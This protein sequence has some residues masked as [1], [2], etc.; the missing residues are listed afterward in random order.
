MMPLHYVRCHLLFWLWSLSSAQLWLLLLYLCFGLFWFV[1]LFVVVVMVLVA[2]VAIVRLQGLLC[3][4]I[5][6]LAAHSGHTLHPPWGSN[7]RPH[8]YGP[9]ALP[10]GL[11]G[12]VAPLC[13]PLCI[14]FFMVGLVLEGAGADC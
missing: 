14:S 11:G 8:G 6:V 7:P 1:V 5:V 3:R 2:C 9:C 4:L 12:L 13:F 10:T